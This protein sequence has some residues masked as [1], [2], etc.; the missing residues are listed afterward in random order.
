MKKKVF[1]GISLMLLLTGSLGYSLPVMYEIKVYPLPATEY[2][3]IQ[4]FQQIG[5]VEDVEVKVYDVNGKEVKQKISY[6]QKTVLN[7]LKEVRLDVTTLKS[8]IYLA[9]I[10]Y[11]NNYFTSKI[12]VE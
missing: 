9:Q 7:L 12:L 10:K 4:F 2:V 11:Q 8:G 6:E 1:I 5:N 3:K